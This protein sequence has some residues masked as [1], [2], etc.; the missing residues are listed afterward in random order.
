[1]TNINTDMKEPKLVLVKITGQCKLRIT[2]ISVLANG[3]T[4]VIMDTQDVPQD[5]PPS[6]MLVESNE[7]K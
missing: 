6:G 2:V 4:F 7:K 5:K 1:M 3:N